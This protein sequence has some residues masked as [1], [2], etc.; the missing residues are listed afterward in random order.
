MGRERSGTEGKRENRKLKSTKEKEFSKTTW[1]FI[2]SIIR[3]H[4]S[5]PPLYFIGQLNYIRRIA[6]LQYMSKTN[7]NRK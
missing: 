6:F 3:F 7:E 1:N 2:L 5:N 4:K